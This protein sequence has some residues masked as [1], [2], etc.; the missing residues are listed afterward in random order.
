MGAWYPLNWPFFLAGITP[1]AIQGE[2]ALH[3]TIA[4]WGAYLFAWGMLRNR[5][6][7]LVAALGYAFSGYFAGHAS[8]LGM[9]Q[10]AAWLPWIL[11]AVE[12]GAS[13]GG[14]GPKVAAGMV[15]GVMALAGHFQTALYT[16]FA[17]A[18][19]SVWLVVRDRSRWVSVAGTLVASAVIGV[20]V[21][22]VM[23]V[24]AAELAEQS[25]RKG[26]EF[27]NA[28]NSPLI[29]SALGTLIYANLFGLHDGNYSGPGDVTQH[30]FY[31]GILLL[32]LAAL[33]L[34]DRRTRWTGVA[35]AVPAAWYAL[36]PGGGLYSVVSKL[37]GLGS[38]RAPVHMWF[39]VAL[40]LAL[41]AGAGSALGGRALEAAVAWMGAGGSNVR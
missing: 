5:A 38:V 15:T 4:A 22:A 28:T 13:E 40:G 20:A 26:M 33:G 41:L 12:R 32:P 21:A 37:P 36:G 27:S 19:Y 11:L 18:A 10:T 35:L 39:I 25:V 2:L 23:I 7:A 34:T 3:S 17:V 1:G 6:A 14:I 24:P 9:F 30:Y 16:G 8:H 29:P 31:A